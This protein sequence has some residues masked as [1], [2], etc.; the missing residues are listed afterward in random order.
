MH[1]NNGLD[2]PGHRSFENASKEGQIQF[3]G[4]PAGSVCFT[5]L[6][7]IEDTEHRV[8]VAW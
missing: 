3:R 2:L 7:L 4:W 6:I 8:A 5:E 1:V